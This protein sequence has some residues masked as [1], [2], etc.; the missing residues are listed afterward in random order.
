MHL[1]KRKEAKHLARAVVVT[2][3]AMLPAAPA[4]AD[5]LAGLTLNDCGLVARNVA[6]GH[7]FSVDH[8]AGT[9]SFSGTASNAVVFGGS[10]VSAAAGDPAGL[11][12][13]IQNGT[14]GVNNGSHLDFTL[15]TTGYE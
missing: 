6:A 12:L 1:K 8:G 5:L 7:T 4:W 10:T 2:G 11:A 3:L 9:L 14:G 15:S 13:A